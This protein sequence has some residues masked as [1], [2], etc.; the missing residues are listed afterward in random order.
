[1][2]FPKPGHKYWNNMTIDAVNKR[3]QSFGFD[4]TPYKI[5]NKNKKG[6]ITINDLELNIKMK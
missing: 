4:I 6:Y 3:Y 1:M 2:G 5:I